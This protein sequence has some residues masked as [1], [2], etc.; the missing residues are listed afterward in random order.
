MLYYS[1][2]TMVFER[3]QGGVN[4]VLQWCHNDVEADLPDRV[5]S[6]SCCPGRIALYYSG[7]TVVLQSNGYC[8]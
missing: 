6:R 1:G 5:T 3:Y 2:V 7:V 4:V 8:E